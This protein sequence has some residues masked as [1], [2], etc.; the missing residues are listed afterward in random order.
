MNILF[1][2]FALGIFFYEKSLQQ[3]IPS[4]INVC[5]LS[6][7]K[8]SQCIR[9]SI[10]SLRPYLNEGIDE[11]DI[12]SLNPLT[13]PEIK[14][15]QN[16]GIQVNA[17]FK[18]IQIYGA[19]EFRLRSV[20]CDTSTDKFRMKIWFPELRM[21]GDYDIQGT[22]LGLP[23]KGQGRAYGNFSDIDGVLSMK[24]DRIEKNDKLHYKVNFLQTEFNIGGAKAQLDNLFNGREKE[25]GA[26]INNFINENWRIVAA[27]IR[28]NLENIISDILKEVADKFFSAFPISS[29]FKP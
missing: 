1:R 17:A 14:L 23:I 25:L 21:M 22:I 9:K 11:L 3:E 24:L 12:P 26:S 8:L 13:V 18:H 15:L 2:I 16:S 7:T 4:Y 19:T 10:L 28:P 6:D 5:S 20:R 27:E 29:L